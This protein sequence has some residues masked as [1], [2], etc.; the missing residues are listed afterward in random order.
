MRNLQSMLMACCRVV[1][2]GAFWLVCKLFYTVNING[3]ERDTGAPHTYLA[4]AHKRDLDPIV[5]LPWLLAHRRWRGWAGDI[6]FALRGDAFSAG[7]LAHLLPNPDWLSY[8][9]H[10]ISIGPV[11]RWLGAHPLEHLH[12]RPTEEWIRELLRVEGDVR[13]G[14]VLAPSLLQD[15]SAT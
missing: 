15:L 5:T 1:I 2:V 7:Y 8:L 10:P 6:H 14:D 12:I 4:I 9:L 11:L 3:L 13:A